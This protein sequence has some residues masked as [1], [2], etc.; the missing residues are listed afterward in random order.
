MILVGPEQNDLVTNPPPWL[1]TASVDMECGT[2]IFADDGG[3]NRWL[4]G[5]RA[6]S[7]Q[8]PCMEVTARG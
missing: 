2:T 6:A 7:A 5:A 3:T 8:T 4:D 1:R